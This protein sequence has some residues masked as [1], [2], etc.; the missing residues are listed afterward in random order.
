MNFI[1][2]IL[3][4]IRSFMWYIRRMMNEFVEFL[5]KPFAFILSFFE[6]VFYFIAKFFQVAVEI[7]QLF[8]ALFQYFFAHAVALMKTLGSFVGFAPQTSYYMPSAARAGF[9]GVIDQI[10]L[11]GVLTTI[12]NILIALIWLVFAVK[13]I[14][15]FGGKGDVNKA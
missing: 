15:L 11:T 1:E 4:S 2:K 12:P 14:S 5:A 10:G 3:E 6:G 7:I 13:M 8:V 9:D